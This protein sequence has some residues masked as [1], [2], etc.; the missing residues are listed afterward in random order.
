M[1]PRLNEPSLLIVLSITTKISVTIS[2]FSKTYI[3]KMKFSVGF[4]T[5]LLCGNIKLVL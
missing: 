2:A 4:Y 1:N 3:S 5:W